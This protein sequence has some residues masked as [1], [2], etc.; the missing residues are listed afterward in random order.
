MALSTYGKIYNL[1]HKIIKDLLDGYVFV[2]EKIDGSQFSFGIKDDKL[3]MRSKNC[4][5]SEYAGDSMFNCALKQVE[6]IKHLLKPGYTYRAEYLKKPK[7]NSLAYNRAP[8]KNLII[9]DIDIH[10]QD[11]MKYDEKIQEAS[12]LGLECAPL[13]WHGQGSDLTEDMFKEFLDLESVLG[14]QKIEGVVIKNYERF[15]CMDGRVLMGKHVSE[16]FKEINHKNHKLQN[17]KSEL[18]ESLGDKYRTVARWE[19]AVQA[20]RDSGELLEAPEDIG[21]LLKTVNLDVLDECK[22]EIKED[23]F[24]W[25]WPK[26]QKLL[27]RGLPQWYKETLITKQFEE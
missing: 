19:K 13:I 18:I 16:A 1:G 6:S 20:L 21:K 25:A 26:L 10:T 23:L 3:F 15:N 11:Y 9:Y 8:E 2:E 7:H 24:K 5:L 14:G 12:I 27:T 17:K 4:D 22:D